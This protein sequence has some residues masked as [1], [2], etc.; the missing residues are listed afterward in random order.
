MAFDPGRIT[1]SASPG[2]A[3]PGR[4][5][6]GVSGRVSVPT[7][8]SGVGI[9]L[10]PAMAALSERKDLPEY[11]SLLAPKPERN[12]VA[13]WP[14]QR[15]LARAANEFLKQISASCKERHRTPSQKGR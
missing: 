8:S 4:R 15:P 7:R 13:V 12:I 10:V 9:S 2:S 5:Y 14:K 1:R 11:R 3:S 6:S